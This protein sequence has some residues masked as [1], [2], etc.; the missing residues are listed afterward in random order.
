MPARHSRRR[1]PPSRRRNERAPAPELRPQAGGVPHRY[2]PVG[3]LGEPGEGSAP[4]TEGLHPG[5]KLGRTAVKL[6]VYELIRIGVR[7]LIEHWP[8][9]A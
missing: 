1:S 4:T 7:W 9:L 2:C 6:L 5:S 3:A 8:S